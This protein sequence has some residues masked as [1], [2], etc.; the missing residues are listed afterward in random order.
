MEVCRLGAHRL[1]AHIQ[2]QG[3]SIIYWRRYHPITRTEDSFTL[4]LLSNCFAL[5][6]LILVA[7]V[8]LMLHVQQ[9]A[10]MMDACRLQ[11]C[12]DPQNN[13]LSKRLG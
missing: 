8:C 10:K 12:N 3:P 6:G 2:C 4:A 9:N 1:E 13:K 5:I 7:K 11:L